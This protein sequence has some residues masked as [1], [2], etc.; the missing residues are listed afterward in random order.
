MI[1]ASA[2]DV[3]LK[4]AGVPIHGCASS[5]RIDFKD[6]A[7]DADRKRAV[8]ILAA[9]DYEACCR[10]EA[11]AKALAALDALC[12]AKAAKLQRR[13]AFMQ[14]GLTAADA[15]VAACDREI[16]ADEVRIAQAVA[17]GGVST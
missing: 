8:E 3:E 17:T 2:L 13:A 1:N 5:G 9:H 6:S 11:Q 12:G 4:A 16:A 10:A 14:A 7:T 15:R